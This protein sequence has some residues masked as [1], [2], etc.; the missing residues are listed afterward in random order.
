MDIPFKA[1]NIIIEEFEEQDENSFSFY[2]YGKKKAQDLLSTDWKML[3]D[4]DEFI[5]KVP[6]FSKLNI[7]LTYRLGYIHAYGNIYSQIK[8]NPEFRRA[9]P[10]VHFGN[11]KIISDGAVDGPYSYK[12]IGEFYHTNT[13]RN[14]VSLSTKWK[15][16][17]EIEMNEGYQDTANRLKFLNNEFDYSCYRD[18]WPSSYVVL[19]DR[20]KIPDI[21][22]ENEHRFS[23]CKFKDLIKEKSSIDIMKSIRCKFGLKNFEHLINQSII[24]IKSKL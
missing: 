16:Q 10:R 23:N 20:S 1:K 2:T 6:N 13:I 9:A 5:V 4:I 8:C 18:I 19:M 21:I 3:L 22:I 17:I 7:K 24:Y 12:I 11:K 14:S 15:K